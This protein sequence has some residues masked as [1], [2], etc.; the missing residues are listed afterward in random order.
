V[1]SCL[2]LLAEEIG[3]VSRKLQSQRFRLAVVGEFSQG[4]STLLNALL[5]EEI[6]PV[7]AIPCSGTVTVLKYGTQ[8]RVVCRYKDGRKKRFL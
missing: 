6:Q 5:G 3:K 2:R 1:I 8:K 4:K 7:R